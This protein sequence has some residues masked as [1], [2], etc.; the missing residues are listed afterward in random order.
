MNGELYEV[1]CITAAAKRALKM[2]TELLFTPLEYKDRTEFQFLPEKRFF[3]TKDYN[4]GNVF[5]WYQYCLKKKLQDI[6]CLVPVS[7]ENRS[8]L[9][10]SNTA[11]SLLVCFYEKGQVTYFSSNWEYDSKQRVWNT[12]YTEYKWENAPLEKPH[13]ENN[14]EAFGAVLSEIGQLARRIDC[15]NF[16]DVFQ[17][18]VT[19]LFRKKIYGVAKI[20]FFMY[21]ILRK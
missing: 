6:K 1:C 14:A 11:Q 5:E 8:I 4:A 16:A 13:F 10:F 15:G 17:R 9:G 2:Q 21:L 19:I 12:L 18:A 3:G 20:Y 7:V